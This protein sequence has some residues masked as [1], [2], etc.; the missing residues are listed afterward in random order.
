MPETIERQ[1]VSPLEL[2]IMRLE[3]TLAEHE[4]EH[5]RTE[6]EIWHTIME[7]QQDVRDLRRMLP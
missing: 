1:E 2:R 6:A 4:R 3:Q 5:E 7:I